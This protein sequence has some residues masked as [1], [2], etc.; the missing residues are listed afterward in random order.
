MSP[1]PSID[2]CSSSGPAGDG[3]QLTPSAWLRQDAFT[4]CL[5]AGFFGFY[6]HA[7]VLLALAHRG[8][9]P[10]RLIG[11]SAGAI[12]AGLHAAGLDPTEI[13]ERIRRVD[14]RDFWDPGWPLGGWL[15]GRALTRMLD[16]TLAQHGVSTFED[17]PLPV[18]VIAHDLLR[19]RGS[20]LRSGPLATAIQ[21]SC[22][23]PLLFRPVVRERRVLLDG[24]L[25]DR[26]GTSAAHADE[27]VLLHRLPRRRRTPRVAPGELPLTPRQGRNR[28]LIH[29]MP[30][31][32]PVS[33]RALDRGP[34]ALDLAYATTL[35]W[36]DTPLAAGQPGADETDQTAGGARNCRL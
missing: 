10:A 7:G 29:T 6:A 20:I 19:R 11:V 5:S 28:Q 4:L 14:H 21:A 22:A 32:S 2:G 23:V 33:P 8:L 13:V 26:D 36:L 27:R 16:R 35:R 31:L 1:S 34:M 9:Q 17:C 25:A 30:E 15:R 18:A 24:G 12:V 3:R